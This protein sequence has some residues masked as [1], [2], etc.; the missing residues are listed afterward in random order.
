MVSNFKDAVDLN[1][2]SFLLIV[3]SILYSFP[4]R[5]TIVITEEPTALPFIDKVLLLVVVEIIFLLLV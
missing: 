5:D 4:E 1:T 2:D 3:I